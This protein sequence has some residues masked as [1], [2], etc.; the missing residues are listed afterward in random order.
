MPF[1]S[2]TLLTLGTCIIASHIEAPTRMMQFGNDISGCF[3]EVSWSIIHTKFDIT[4]T[5]HVLYDK[6]PSQPGKTWFAMMGM[7]LLAGSGVSPLRSSEA[8]QP[9][10]PE[11]DI[12]W[13]GN[14]VYISGGTPPAIVSIK[15]LGEITII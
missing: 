8:I 14:I 13:R 2:P 15:I 4:T 3:Y 6:A 9:S 10:N 11:R 5:T 1:V 7:S 12:T